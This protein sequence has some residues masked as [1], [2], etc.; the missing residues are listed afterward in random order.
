M[1]ADGG[2][3]NAG[4]GRAAYGASLP[5]AVA[6]RVNEWIII[7]ELPLAHARGYTPWSSAGGVQALASAFPA[8]RCPSPVY[9]CDCSS[10]W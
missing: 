1:G 8:L 9:F 7:I 6:T 10:A 2:R 3:R 5:V 4:L